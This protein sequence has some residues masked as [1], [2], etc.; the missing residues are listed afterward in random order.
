MEA[1]QTSYEKKNVFFIHMLGGD[2][3]VPILHFKKHYRLN[4]PVIPD[5]LDRLRH[6]IRVSGIANVAVFGGDGVCVFNK[7]V[8]E[9]AGDFREVIDQALKK[10]EGPNRKLSAFIDG[11]TVYAPQVKEA[12]KIIHQRMPALSASPK[13][14]V[15]LVYVSD[16]SGSNDVF[17]KSLAKDAWGKEYPVA[18]SK[19]DEYSPAVAAVGKGQ[20]LVAYVS[21][22]RG[23]Y[24]IY[25]VLMKNGKPYKR[26]QVTRS[27]DD[28]MAPQLHLGRMG[29]LW[30]VWYEW[31]KMG[32]LSRDREILAAQFRGGRWSK[33]I[34]V[35]PR[36][37][38]TYE[39]HAEPVVFS[40][41]R[42]G[43][44]V[45]WAW[46]YHGTL[47]K[48]VPLEENS[49]FIRYLDRR[50]QPGEILAVGYRG[51][52]RARDYVPAL[53]VTPDGIPWVAWDNSH[54]ASLGYSAKAIF[55]NRLVGT[56]F[57]EQVEAAA[58]EGQIDSPRLLL[59][60]KGAL[61]LLWGQETRGGWELWCREVK[62]GGLGD[63][64]KLTLQ[65]KNPR[66]PAGCFDS[67]G[68]LWVA[69]TDAGKTKWEVRVE[70]PEL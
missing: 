12:G 59:H 45:A 70:A 34:Q 60:P 66:F 69:Y 49:I 7:S 61:H 47:Q 52:G 55:V 38:P 67:T 51:E 17:I 56:D 1:L 39:D 68:K 8:T 10:I 30:M 3:E 44:W 26:Q 32:D 64:R 58:H 6:I 53:A 29:D 11:G 24:D 50:M 46:D 57:P 41:G 13:G 25:T 35:S 19:A 16:E 28:A 15:V 18:A 20:A 43:A 33:P 23:R 48:K 5:N 65:G 62:S 37:V 4:Y 9:E 21:N 2:E 54:K 22:E 42:G 31:A 40:D 27:R 14:D 63:A 36:N